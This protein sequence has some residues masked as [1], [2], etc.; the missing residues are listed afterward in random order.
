MSGRLQT[1]LRAALLA[2]VVLPAAAQHRGLML[3]V[4]SPDWR[5]QVI[6]VSTWDW[7][8]GWRPLAR[9]PGSFIVGGGAPQGPKFWSASPVIRLP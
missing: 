5:D 8:G 4:P 6:Y 3:H 7:D 2:A 1:L 9:E